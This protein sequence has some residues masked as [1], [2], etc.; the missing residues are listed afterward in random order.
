[1]STLL[2]PLSETEK[3]GRGQ[4]RHLSQVGPSQPPRLLGQSWAQASQCLLAPFM[5]KS[6][7]ILCPFQFKR[8]YPFPWVRVCLAFPVFHRTPHVFLSG[9]D[10]DHLERL[11]LAGAGSGAGSPEAQ[12]GGNWDS[13]GAAG[14]CGFHRSGMAPPVLRA[15]HITLYTL[16]WGSAPLFPPRALSWN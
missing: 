4:G 1:M 3:G 16:L 12:A 6:S 14:A 13:P 10:S 11:V 9:F 2:S 15:G 8:K 7:P 5:V